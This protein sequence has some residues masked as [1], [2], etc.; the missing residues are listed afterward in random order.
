[1]KPELKPGM[2]A[3]RYP[4]YRGRGG[5][6]GVASEVE[7]V[8]VNRCSVTVTFKPG[9]YSPPLVRVP[10]DEL[11]NVRPKPEVAP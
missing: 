10:A 9:D 8:R 1:M 6:G 7:I 3:T 2:L 11:F 5:F 4:T